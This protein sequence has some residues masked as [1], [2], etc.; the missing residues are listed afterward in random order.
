MIVD[1][2][3]DLCSRLTTNYHALSLTIISYHKLPLNLN[4]FQIFTIV[5]DS[6]SGLTTCMIV[7]DSERNY[8]LA[9]YHGL[10]NRLTRP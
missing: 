5:D 4:T 9:N 10:S 8:E 6:F 2:S 3:P 1:D 7:D